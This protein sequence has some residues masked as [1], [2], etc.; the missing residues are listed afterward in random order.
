MAGEVYRAELLPGPAGG[1]GHGR[2]WPTAC[3]RGGFEH[4]RFPWNVQMSTCHFPNCQ[5]AALLAALTMETPPSLTRCTRL[6]MSSAG[7]PSNT[8]GSQPTHAHGAGETLPLRSP[9][10][11]NCSATLPAPHI[12][13]S[14]RAGQAGR[15]G[16]ATGLAEGQGMFR[17]NWGR[18]LCPR[19]GLVFTVEWLRGPIAMEGQWAA[20]GGRAG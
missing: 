11:A 16:D 5:T 3:Q 18:T 15:E 12:G 13:V 8:A 10:A 1:T 9:E 2:A 4:S 19:V 6:Y 17:V 20:G 7:K 14:G